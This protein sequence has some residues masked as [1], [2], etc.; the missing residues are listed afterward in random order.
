[1]TIVI[2]TRYL[3]V[4]TSIRI[5]A[6]GL[7]ALGLAACGEV[8]PIAPDAMSAPPDAVQP[9]D[10]AA[11]DASAGPLV[12]LAHSNTQSIRLGSTV[13]CRKADIMPPVQAD[14]SYFRVFRLAD[15]GVEGDF[16][17]ADVQIG[18]ESADAA[19]GTQPAQVFLYTLAEGLPLERA[20]LALV[21][22]QS[23]QIPDQEASIHTMP[24][25]AVI[26]A[27]ATLVV[28]FFVPDGSLLDNRFF[29][30][31]NNDGEQDP[32]YIEAP[33]CDS[34]PDGIVALTMAGA[35]FEGRAVILNVRGHDL[36][37]AP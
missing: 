6:L 30:G 19:D 20:N 21:T 18:V 5:L 15:F 35:G 37:R 7:A 10:A 27:G 13:F 34:V 29:V 36:A 8:K 1:M 32:S 16:E 26:P 25:A 31:C 11:P 12:T 23:Y 17:V 28:E 9:V 22:M 14:N 24:I 4:R 2:A 33:S 3:L